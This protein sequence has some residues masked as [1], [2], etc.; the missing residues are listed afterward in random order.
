MTAVRERVNLRRLAILLAGLFVLTGCQLDVVADVVVNP[1]GTG[2]I[3]VTVEADAELADEV[4]TIADELVLDDVRAAGWIVDG[5]NP[6]PEGGLLLTLNHD[7]EGK[8]EATN[9]LRS[10]GPPFNDPTIGRGQDGD[11]ATN[12]ARANLGLPDGF[13]AFAD[14]DLQS[15]LGGVPFAARL[16]E[17]GVDPSTSFNA[18]LRVTLPGELV[19]EETNAEVLDDGT[20]QWNVPVDGTVLEASARSEQSPSTGGVWA[21]PVA[22]LALILL[23][24]WLGFMVIFI[25]YVA[26]ARWRRSRRY[27]RR[28]LP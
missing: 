10:L 18:E 13:A 4:P 12:V 20:L 1:D 25:I 14:D 28:A 6:T 3:V 24:T 19:A 17:A 22:T 27:R 11:S 8:D 7:F 2:T 16:E 23:I 5:P 15:A 21:R 9:L 26:I